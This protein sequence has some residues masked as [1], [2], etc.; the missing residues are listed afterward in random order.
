[1]IR[2]LVGAAEAGT[3]QPAGVDLY[4]DNYHYNLSRPL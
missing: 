4:I 3:W 1:L 2:T